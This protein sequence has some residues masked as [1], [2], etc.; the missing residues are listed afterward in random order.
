MPRDAPPIQQ[1]ARR[2][3]DRKAT[4]SN[5]DAAHHAIAERAG[6]GGDL[7]IERPVVRAGLEFD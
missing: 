3:F 7:D 4:R 1:S 5:G 2:D 6:G